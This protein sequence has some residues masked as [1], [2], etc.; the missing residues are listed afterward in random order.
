MG[1]L[2]YPQLG[3]GHTRRESDSAASWHIGFA[4]EMRLV[5]LVTNEEF[6]NFC[7]KISAHTFDSCFEKEIDKQVLEMVATRNL[8]NK[9]TASFLKADGATATYQ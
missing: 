8:H 1:L 4:R 6:Q 7:M 9:K 3:S 2:T 5:Q